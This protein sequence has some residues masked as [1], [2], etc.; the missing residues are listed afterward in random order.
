MPPTLRA[1]PLCS[2]PKGSASA[3]G[4]CQSWR[5]RPWVP[6][7]LCVA[8]MERGVGGGGRGGAEGQGGDNQR[9]SLSTPHQREGVRGQRLP[10]H[11]PSQRCHSHCQ[12]Q[13]APRPPA[14]EMSPQVAAPGPRGRASHSTLSLPTEFFFS[15][16]PQH[17]LH[18]PEVRAPW[19]P[20]PP[21]SGGAHCF[22]SRGA[23]PGAAGTS[24]GRPRHGK[25][26][27]GRPR[28]THEAARS[29]RGSHV[30]GAVTS[31]RGKTQR[32]RD[33]I[34]VPAP[35]LMPP[36]LKSTQLR[37]AA[38]LLTSRG[39]GSHPESREVREQ[40]HMGGEGSL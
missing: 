10:M 37:T 13:R 12:R 24:L 22:W 7:G 35:P 25:A 3:A 32:G 6:N 20:T 9:C 33:T 18:C 16:S 36:F 28:Q 15:G 4:N 29:P 31:G 27:S 40:G 17:P 34:L 11:C 39:P 8:A 14:V 23:G 5:G 19:D 1:C 21:R 30:R 26:C 38:D 2:Y